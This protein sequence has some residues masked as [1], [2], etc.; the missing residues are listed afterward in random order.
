MQTVKGFN[1]RDAGPVFIG[2][3]DVSINPG[4]TKPVTL[5]E[6]R[7]GPT[8]NASITQKQAGD[9]LDALAKDLAEEKGLTYDKAFDRVCKQEPELLA[10]YIPASQKAG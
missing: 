5:S 4:A 6:N 7:G 2:A 3:A 1:G 10:A 8:M 9:K